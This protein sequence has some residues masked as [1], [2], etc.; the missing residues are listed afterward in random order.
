MS[1]AKLLFTACFVVFA[2]SALASATASAGEWMVEGKPL[3]GSE[4]LAT[5]ALVLAEGEL[6]VLPAVTTIKCRAHEIGITGGKIIAPDGVLATS[7]S[8]KECEGEGACTEIA[9][10]GAIKT[11]PVH[12]LALLDG[13]LNTYI[14]VLPETKTTFAT[15]G[16]TSEN[17]ALFPSQP[18]TGS[19]SLL[20]H[21]G[22]DE[23]V[24]HRVLAFSLPKALKVGSSEA[25]LRGA[26]ADIEL[27][28]KKPWSFL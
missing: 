9:N 13:P 28:S 24:I 1:R 27:K 3:S 2:L 19:A 15:I 12:G 7:I 14:S 11:L 20:A 17:C 4:E 16:F 18:V 6:K 5:G 23:R 25:D 10:G 8:F 26:V 21:E 22:F